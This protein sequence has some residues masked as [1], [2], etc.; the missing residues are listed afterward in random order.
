MNKDDILLQAQ[1]ENRGRDMADM[2]AQKKGAYVAYFAGILLIILVCVAEGVVLGRLNC[3]GA[4]VVFAMGFT[5]FLIKYLTLR[6]RHELF[7]ALLYGALTV[8]CLVLWIL[9]L[10][11]VMT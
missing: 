3:G 4:A 7:V 6:K 9:Q 8:L 10:C 5:A 11:G 2:E 1:T